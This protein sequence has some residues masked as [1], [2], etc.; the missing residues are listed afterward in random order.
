MENKNKYINYII[1]R[2]IN[3][4]PNQYVEIYSSIYIKDFAIELKKACLNK[5]A[6]FVY[7]DFYD[8]QEEI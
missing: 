8:S 7:I 4:Q 5:G 3:L 2:G 1:D 6:S